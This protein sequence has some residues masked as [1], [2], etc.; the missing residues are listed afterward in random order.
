MVSSCYLPYIACT[1]KKDN[2]GILLFAI[3][4]KAQTCRWRLRLCLRA[5]WVSF[6][7]QACQCSRQCGRHPSS[8]LRFIV[9]FARR[10]LHKRHSGW[11]GPLS[12][13]KKPRS[14]QSRVKLEI[15][16]FRELLRESSLPTTLKEVPIMMLKLAMQSKMA[17]KSMSF[18]N[19]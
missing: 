19:I 3:S 2:S 13:V 9:I 15:H 6:R 14:A 16:S 11:A 1:V 4:T 12:R 18:F 8:F 7:R 5:L 10:P 17:S